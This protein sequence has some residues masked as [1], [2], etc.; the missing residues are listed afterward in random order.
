M[1]NPRLAVVDKS[2]F[3]LQFDIIMGTRSQEL[4]PLKSHQSHDWLLKR[5]VK[6]Q[7]IEVHPQQPGWLKPLSLW[8]NSSCVTV[9][10][11]SKEALSSGDASRK[12]SQPDLRPLTLVQS[13]FNVKH[14]LKSL[15]ICQSVFVQED[16]IAQQNRYNRG[17][18][19]RWQAAD[20]HISKSIEQKIPWLTL[21]GVSTKGSS[22]M[23]WIKRS[24]D[25]TKLAVA[26]TL[27]LVINVPVGLQGI[28]PVQAQLTPSS[29][30]RSLPDS[31]NF[32][33]PNRGNPDNRE[34]GA[35][36]GPDCVP[37]PTGKNPT[38]YITLLGPEWESQPKSNTRSLL[39]A[40]PKPGV[41]STISAYPTFY[42]Y[43]PETT[44][45]SM[46]FALR[47]FVGQNAG[48]EDGYREIYTTTFAI[49]GNPG[50]VSLRLPPYASL[51]PLEV[52]KEYSWKLTLVCDSENDISVAGSIKRVPVDPLLANRI[53]TA[54]LEQR[55]ELYADAQLWQ[56]TLTSLAELRRLRP[57]DPTIAIAWEKLLKSAGLGAVAKE[58]LLQ[59]TADSR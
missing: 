43:V 25:L 39:N 10:I 15:Q 8:G 51:S 38:K 52:G 19:Y 36:R 13:V 59:S 56:E 34:G 14:L 17:E 44:A 12:Q 24:S 5:T 46:K 11:F 30:N 2:Q 6:S 45:R 23:I 53:A 20:N 57:N 26:L 16:S 54:T 29:L 7:V 47:E 37:D 4:A 31:W 48:D 50:I 55:V 41:S 33:P 49:A 21:W 1:P 42:W 3:P 58:P 9:P 32:D 27:G 22:T 40:G 28:E 18:S 35:T